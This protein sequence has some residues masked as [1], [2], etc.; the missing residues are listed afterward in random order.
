VKTS[1]KPTQWRGKSVVYASIDPAEQKKQ[2]FIGIIALSIFFLGLILI[3][4]L[5]R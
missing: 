5:T 2:T 4:W 1:Y 3:V